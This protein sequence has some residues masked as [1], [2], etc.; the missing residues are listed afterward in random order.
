MT[1]T[2]KHAPKPWRSALGLVVDE[3]DRLREVNTKLLAA[4]KDVVARLGSKSDNLDA[5]RA[6]IAKAQEARP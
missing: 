5:L 2:E 1:K 6:A 4:A 3:R